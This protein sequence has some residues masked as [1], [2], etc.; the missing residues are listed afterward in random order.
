MQEEVIGYLKSNKLV[1]CWL[2]NGII[3]LAMA[4]LYSVILVIIRTPQLS[5]FIENKEFFKVALV[6]HVNLSVL[7][8]LMSITAII[9]SYRLRFG[10]FGLLCGRL[11]IFATLLL[12][13]SPF[14]GQSMAVMNN[15]IPMLENIVFIIGLSLFGISMLLLAVSVIINAFLSKQDIII[16]VALS[17]AVMWIAM[18]LCFIL[19]YFSLERLISSTFIGIDLY[20]ELLYWSGGHLLQFVYTQT[21]MIV[22]LILSQLWL[23][24]NL[25]F[26]KFCF[27]L[28]YLNLVLALAALIGHFIY[29]IN[30]PAFRHYYTAHMQ[31]C[32]GIAPISVLLLIIYELLTRQKLALPLIKASMLGSIALFIAGGVIGVLIS[33]AN[34]TIP[35]HYHG[36]IVGISIGFMGFAYVLC[37]KNNQKITVVTTVF[38]GKIQIYV[39]TIGQILHIIGLSISG[40]YGALRKSTVAELQLPVKM[41][42][43]LMGLGGLIAI[44]G[45]LMFVAI[46]GRRLFVNRA[47]NS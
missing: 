41:A 38:P 1:E 31:Y 42:M 26:Y 36:S 9:W 20:Y 29:D 17:S 33:G 44:I 12:G 14:C 16:F 8:W 45:G 46:C 15:Y 11:S 13:L 3:S 40:G 39:M 30:A 19:S 47:T 43:A 28:L 32:G 22:W 4:G 7:V 10:E 2:K 6:V 18:W 24:A 25:H 35:A 21:I 27:F 23:G 5:A 37:T 34:V